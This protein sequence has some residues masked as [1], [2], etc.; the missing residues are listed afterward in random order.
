MVGAMMPEAWASRMWRSTLRRLPKAA[1]PQARIAISVT[2]RA[3]SDAEAFDSSTS[4]NVAEPGALI[5]FVLVVSRYYADSIVRQLED[6][7]YPAW[8]IGEVR[9]GEPGVEFVA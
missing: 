7:G 6:E 4:S 9:D 5:G 1:P 3:A 8:V 2:W